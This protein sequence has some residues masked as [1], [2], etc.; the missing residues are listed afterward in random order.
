MSVPGYFVTRR[1]YLQA[2]LFALLH[3]LCDLLQLFGQYFSDPWMLGIYKDCKL[4]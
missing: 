4:I 1:S 3:V 2:E